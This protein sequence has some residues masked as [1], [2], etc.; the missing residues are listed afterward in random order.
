MEKF[1]T[2]KFTFW[3][4]VIVFLIKA[5]IASGGLRKWVRN[6]FWSITPSGSI[7]DVTYDSV[8]M[9]IMPVENF[10]ER[11]IIL[12]RK[13]YDGI[14]VK[15]ITSALPENGV[16]LDLGANFGYYSLMVAS[17]CPTAK[18]IAYEPN[19]RVFERMV[20][21]IK[22]NNFDNIIAIDSAIGDKE[23]T[24]D[25]QIEKDSAFSSIRNTRKVE[26]KSQKIKVETL[27]N[28]LEK[29]GIKKPHALKIDVEGFE[30]KALLPYFNSVDKKCYPDLIVIEYTGEED[31]D[32]NVI[33]FLLKNGYYESD[34]T[35]GNLILLRE[36]K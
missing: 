19:P 11:A 29:L 17:K 21:N 10:L 1:G 26:K 5:R 15:A 18:I 35:T 9:R 14:E 34:R 23:G 20:T 28:S 27:K 24:A 6:L 36:Q 7:F 32:E 4:G 16:F 2:Y 33:E 3:Q 22:L 13:I 12:H 31:W 8:R 25:L 30:D